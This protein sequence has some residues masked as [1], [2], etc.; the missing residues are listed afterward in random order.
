MAYVVI[1]A[2]AVMVGE[3]EKDLKKLLSKA[4][5]FYKDAYVKEVKVYTGCI[6]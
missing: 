6:H 1:I 2:S 5:K 3:A 4:K